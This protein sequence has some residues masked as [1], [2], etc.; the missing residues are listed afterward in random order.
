[1]A[2]GAI[3]LDSYNKKDRA[4]AKDTA[5]KLLRKGQSL[6]IYPE[7]AWNI[8]PNL[9]VMKLFSGAADIAITAGVD[10][11]PVGIIQDGIKDYYLSI[12]ENISTKNY[13]AK[14]KYL[15]TARLRDK[16]ATEVWNAMEA[17]PITKRETL[18]G[19]TRQEFEDFLTSQM[20]GAFT[21]EDC[22]NER[23]HDKGIVETG[24]AF[25]HLSSV[26]LNKN[27][28]FLFNKRNHD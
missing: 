10:I 28:A 24:D 27:S 2:N 20:N 6:L 11:V 23:Y 12:G 7:G 1:M 21:I 3:C 18:S 13:G 15:L 14:D 25:A 17:L 5:I 4:I 19:N 9:P 22:E 26:F 16:I 8:T